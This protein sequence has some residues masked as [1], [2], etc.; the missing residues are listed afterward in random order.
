MKAEYKACF[1]F[2]GLL[3]SWS[4]PYNETPLDTIELHPTPDMAKIGR[5]K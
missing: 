2:A 3:D 1:L 5:Y 4:H